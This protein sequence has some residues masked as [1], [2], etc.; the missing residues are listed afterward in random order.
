MFSR[1][2]LSSVALLAGQ[3]TAGFLYNGLAVTPQMGWVCRPAEYI[4]FARD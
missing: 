2:I 1:T 3:A 4:V